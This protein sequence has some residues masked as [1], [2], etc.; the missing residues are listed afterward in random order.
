[1]KHKLKRA[2]SAS[3]SSTGLLVSSRSD[4]PSFPF[5]GLIQ[6]A[7]GITLVFAI[8]V[9][10]SYLLG[11]IG[12]IFKYLGID[13][14]GAIVVKTGEASLGA[15]IGFLVSA[16]SEGLNKPFFALGCVAGS[17]CY[18]VWVFFIIW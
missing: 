6:F 10:L 16:L 4:S 8:S 18:Y 11:I 5:A 15:A 13:F 17:I 2:K 7:S 9:L 3:F 12:A 14:V 1:M